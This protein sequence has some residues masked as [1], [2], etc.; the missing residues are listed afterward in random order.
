MNGAVY[1]GLLRQAFYLRRSQGAM[2][3]VWLALLLLLV[4]PLASYYFREDRVRAVTLLTALVYVVAMM[5]W[6]PLVRAMAMLNMPSHAALV[7]HGAR[8]A[9]RLV[10]AA[11]A[12]LVFM[13]GLTT[14]LQ[15]DSF[16]NGAIVGSLL[17]AGGALLGAERYEGM[18]PY[19]AAVGTAMYLAEHAAMMNAPALLWPLGALALASGW[20]AMERLFPRSVERQW[21]LRERSENSANMIAGHA[22]ASPHEVP[23]PLAR[24]YGVLL[25]RDCA[26]DA[27]PALLLHA[28]GPKAHWSYGLSVMLLA[29][30]LMA[31]GVIV[32]R[33]LATTEFAHDFGGGFLTGMYAVLM[34]F[35]MVAVVQSARIRLA[36]TAAEQALVRLAPAMP[37]GQALNRT[38]AACLLGHGA[39]LAVMCVLLVFAGTAFASQDVNKALTLTALVST[40]FLL[41]PLLLHDIAGMGNPMHV[42]AL[43]LTLAAMGMLFGAVALLQVPLISVLPVSV[44]LS[45]ALC[46][47]RWRALVGGPV[48]LPAGRLA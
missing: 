37:Q 43:A 23:G 10:L 4:A 34:I 7:P 12:L 41:L 17:L 42:G 9:R 45:A 48:A 35:S 8:P 30:L 26:A 38:L 47:W 1:A 22:D 28:L 36:R 13:A 31:V 2:W 40:V 19:G 27:R 21:R 15:W 44:L 39:I 25:Q 5:L 16:A 11:A 18:V 32:L 33:L 14:M 46:W 6:Q 3:L 24:C 20:Y 29:T